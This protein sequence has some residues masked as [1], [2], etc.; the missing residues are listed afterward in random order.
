MIPSPYWPRE[1]Y[2]PAAFPPVSPWG[3]LWPRPQASYRGPYAFPLPAAQ[4]LDAFSSGPAASRQRAEALKEQGNAWRRQGQPLRAIQAYAHAIDS[5][6]SYTDPYFN[7]GQAYLSLGD[8]AQAIASFQ[9]LLSVDPGDHDAR[10]VMA[11]QMMLSGRVAEAQAQYRLTLTQAPTFDPAARQWAYLQLLTFARTQS[12]PLA[13]IAAGLQ[14]AGSNGLAQ[15]RRLLGE[16]LVSHGRAALM[17]VL[18]RARIEFASTQQVNNVA[19]MAEY[20]HFAGRVIRFAPEMAF[21]RPNVL[22]A[23]LAHELVHAADDDA[24][25]SVSEEQDG[26]RALA[27][28]WG[29][30]KGDTLDPNLDLALKYLRENPPRL[31]QKVRELYR[32]REPGLGD[33]SPGHGQPLRS[34]ETSAPTRAAAPGV[35]TN[36]LTSGR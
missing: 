28:V 24:V 21:A 10:V 13:T 1:S 31:N 26:Y 29:A 5:D 19:N 6:P 17:P 9:R 27:D 2:G 18:D 34:P 7:M 12:D 36:A 25:T 14:Q 8:R 3:P 22:A 33:T 11:N 23:Y 16:Y 30:L 32:L 15:A 4:G 35:W 20:D